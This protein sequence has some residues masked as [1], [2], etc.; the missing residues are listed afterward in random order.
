MTCSSLE[1]LLISSLVHVVAEVFLVLNEG[2]GSE[3][4]HSFDEKAAKLS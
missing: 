1:N 2:S 3:F 4:H